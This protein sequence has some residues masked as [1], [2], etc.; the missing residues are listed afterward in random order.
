MCIIQICDKLVKRHYFLTKTTIAQQLRLNEQIR[1]P[2]LVVIDETGA[3]LGVLSREKALELAA[4]RGLDLVEL[5]TAAKPPV[6]RLL[7]YGKFLYEQQKKEKKKR[8]GQKGQELKTVRI[9]IKT[10]EHD[11]GTKARQIEKFLEK[12][13]KVRV[14]IF[15]RGRERAFK[16]LARE[17]LTLFVE[18]LGKDHRVLEPIKDSPRGLATTIAK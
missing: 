4:E 8:L 18:R 15:L 5:N 14:E 13:H 6:A 9:K 10:S 11:L 3:N 17:R 12:G 1:S 16:N 2:E 7:D